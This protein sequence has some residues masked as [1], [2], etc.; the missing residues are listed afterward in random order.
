MDSPA[1]R[2]ERHMAKE[3]IVGYIARALTSQ[4]AVEIC[5]NKV[6]LAARFGGLKVRAENFRRALDDVQRK[7]V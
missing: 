4:R 1:D 5:P 2:L 7:R 3:F 6:F